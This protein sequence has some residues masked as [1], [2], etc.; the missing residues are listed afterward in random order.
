MNK[1]KLWFIGLMLLLVLSTALAACGSDAG[2][3]QEGRQQ[4]R[5]VRN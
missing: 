4:Q 1:R 3:W 5:K 2:R